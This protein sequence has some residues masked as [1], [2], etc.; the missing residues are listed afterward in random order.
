MSLLRKIKHTI[1]YSFLI[2]LARELKSYAR[3]PYEK[4][5]NSTFRFLLAGI[6]EKFG[7]KHRMEIPVAKQWAKIIKNSSVSANL[8]KAPK[9]TGPRILFATGYSFPSDASRMALESILA[10]SLQLRGAQ[11]VSLSCKKALPACEWNCYGNHSLSIGNYGPRM[12]S[13]TKLDKCNLCTRYNSNLYKQLNIPQ[14][15]FSDFIEPGDLQRLSQI[16]DAQSYKSYDD[17]VYKGIK[18][19]EHARSSVM[20]SLLRGTLE[21]DAYTRWLYRRYLISALF[22]TELTERIFAAIRPERVIAVHGIYVTHGTICEIARKHNIPVVVYGIPYRQGTVWLSH[23][24]TYHRTL[25]TEPTSLWENLSLTPEQERHL[26]S[27]LDSKRAGGRDYVNYH[28]NPLENRK[29]IIEELDLNPNKPIISLFTNVIW[30]AQIY[31]K[32]NAFENIIDWLLQTIRYFSYRPE[33][34]LV[35]R[36]HPAEVKGGIPTNQPIISEI[37]KYIEIFPKNIKIVPPESNVSSYTLAEMSQAALIYGTK[38]GLEI[39]IR[40]IPVIVA[41]ETF[42]RGKGFTYDVGSSKQYFSLLDRITNLPRNSPEMISRAKKFAYHLF[43]RRMIDFP[44][45]QFDAYTFRGTKLKFQ[46]LE[47][48]LPGNN[49]NLD[50]ICKGILN[51]SPFIVD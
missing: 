50:I 8:S 9:A 37:K 1:I 26:D 36:V 3:T 28:P 29:K 16:V 34:Q 4:W 19:G 10:K 21:D 44:L 22:I 48:L 2:P 38:T 14:I 6:C 27:Y 41:G 35:I 12:F 32:Y 5:K 20:R 25:V 45:L 23:D 31:Y 42:N 39:A 46:H 43:F 33:L 11:I 7:I 40:G 17:F 13:K 24:D 30:D 18:V 49:R 51:G 47:D 15:S